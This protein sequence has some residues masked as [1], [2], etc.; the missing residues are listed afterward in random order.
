MK[1]ND[2]VDAEN[3]LAHKIHQDE[4]IWTGLYDAQGRA[5]YKTMDQIG[6][7]R[8]SIRRQDHEG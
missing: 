4:D 1:Y 7:N 5:I 2:E 6:F 3:Y 8:G